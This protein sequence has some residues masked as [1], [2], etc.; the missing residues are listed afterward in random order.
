M[1]LSFPIELFSMS[2][3]ESLDF[4]QTTQQMIREHQLVFANQLCSKVSE[5]VQAYCYGCEIDHPSQTHHTCLMLTELEHFY[6]YRDEAYECCSKDM[7]TAYENIISKFK[8]LSS[9]AKFAFWRLLVNREII[10][11]EDNVFQLVKR[12]ITLRNRFTS[13][14]DYSWQCCIYIRQFENDQSNHSEL[15]FSKSIILQ[16]TH[17]AKKDARTNGRRGNPCLLWDSFKNTSRANYNQS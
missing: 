13:Q 3:T 17:W 10:V 12:M 9:E 7:L 2:V 8:D 1:W 16:Q 11:E 4:N 6:L 15:C 5:L 14:Q